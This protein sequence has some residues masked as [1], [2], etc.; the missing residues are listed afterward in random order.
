MASIEDSVKGSGIESIRVQSDN[1]VDIA[2]EPEGRRWKKR[3]N[4]VGPE[5]SHEDVGV[6]RGKGRAHSG[7]TNLLIEMIAKP[8]TVVGKDKLDELCNKFDLESREGGVF[9]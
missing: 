8:E 3:G 5:V 7:T 9:G 6:G 1:V 4:G 2:L